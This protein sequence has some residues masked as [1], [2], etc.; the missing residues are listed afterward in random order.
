MARGTAAAVRAHGFRAP[1]AGKTGTSHD[2]WFAGYTSNLICI[3]WVG[4]DDYTDVKLEGAK[5]AAPLW[6][7]FM[8]RAIKLP[9]YSDTKPFTPPDGVQNLRI[10]RTT[11]LLADATCPNDLNLSFLNGTGPQS[12]CSR[13]T[14]SPQTLVQELFGNTSSP[15]PPVPRQ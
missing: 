4:N 10:D 6:A 1:A 8:N 14:E 2:A 7:E 5:A 3:I 13:M 15:P 9:Q 12:T 11:S